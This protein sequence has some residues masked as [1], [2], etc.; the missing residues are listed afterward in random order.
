MRNGMAAYDGHPVFL[1]KKE[2]DLKWLSASWITN[3]TFYYGATA[4]IGIF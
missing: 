3:S 2:A 4:K 1:A